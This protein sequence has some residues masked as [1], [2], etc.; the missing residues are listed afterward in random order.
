MTDLGELARPRRRRLDS[1][2][3]KDVWEWVRQRA[4]EE[5]LGWAA[6]VLN[7]S[8]GGLLVVLKWTQDFVLIRY[9]KTT[10]LKE[11]FITYK[12]KGHVLPCRAMRG[13]T[14]GSQEAEGVRGKC[15]KPP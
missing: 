2:A 12:R 4:Q 10:A 13:S 5:K 8:P 14:R 6:H 11:V 15:W 9:S 3:E 1:P 7:Q